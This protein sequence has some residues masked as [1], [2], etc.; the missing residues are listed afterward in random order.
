MRHL[1]HRAEPEQT[2]GDNVSMQRSSKASRGA[3]DAIANVKI[4]MTKISTAQQKGNEGT[5]GTL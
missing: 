3:A 4:T 1:F 2:S 5:D